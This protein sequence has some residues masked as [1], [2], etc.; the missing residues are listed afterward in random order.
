[1]SRAYTL[2]TVAVALNVEPKWLDNI[3]THH[4]V[5]GVPRKRQGNPRRFTGEPVLILQIALNLTQSFGIP[6]SRTLSLAQQL[7]DG[8]G[9]LV[10]SNGVLLSCDLAVI[11]RAISERL[12]AAVEV[13]PLPRRGRPPRNKTG[14]LD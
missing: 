11:Q 7:I 3:L 1:M 2:A 9:S 4:H 8:G 14:R 10:G 6:T 12:D 5:R 13:V